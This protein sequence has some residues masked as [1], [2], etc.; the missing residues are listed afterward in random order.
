MAVIGIMPFELEF[1]SDPTTGVI[2]E[3]W[4]KTVF[5]SSPI[6]NM[7][8][9]DRICLWLDKSQRMLQSEHETEFVNS[10]SDE[11]RQL[12]NRTVGG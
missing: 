8:A 3:C 10:L 4:R 1:F 11:R 12:R 5:I 7:F 2:G 6:S 9:L